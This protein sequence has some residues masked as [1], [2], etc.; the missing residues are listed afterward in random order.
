MTA[1]RSTGAQGTCH[2]C[3]MGSLWGVNTSVARVH[4]LL[5]ATSGPW[6]LDEISEK[7]A[8]SKSNVSMS[9]KELRTWNVVRRVLVAGERREFWTCQPDVWKMLFSI[10]RERKR[11]EFDPA[12]TAVASA[13]APT[14]QERS[15]IPRDMMDFLVG[16]EGLMERVF[17][18]IMLRNIA[19]LLRR[20]PVFGI[21]GRGDYGIQP[22]YVDDLAALMVMLGQGQKDVTLDAVGLGSFPSLRHA[23]TGMSWPS[24]PGRVA[25]GELVV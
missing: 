2:G 15:G 17:W 19:Y 23:M 18:E 5:I 22:V 8:I 1:C 11:R 13:L 10:L 12:R 3:A 14:R 16:T 4:G 24:G 6:C 7:L 21:A 25:P 9:L 20:L